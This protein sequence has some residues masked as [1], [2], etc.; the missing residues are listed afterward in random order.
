MNKII[1][2]EEITLLL[3]EDESIL[4][5]KIIN[6]L[7]IKEFELLKYEIVKKAI[8]SRNKK[9]I[10]FVYS[11]DIELKNNELF[12]ENKNLKPK[13]K[14]NIKRHKIRLIEPFIYEIP[15]ISKNPKNRPIIIWTWPSWLFA[16]LALALAWLKPII[17]E[18]WS[19]VEK[20]VSQVHKFFTTW[21]LD[22]NSNVQF[23]EWWA[24]TFSDWKLYTL[25][26]DKRS[27]FIFS[28]FVEAGAP[29]EILYNAKPHIWTDRLRGVVRNLRKKIISLGWEFYF[30]TLMTDIEVENWKIKAVFLIN[31]EKLNTDDLILAIWHS[32]R[33][34][35][36]M[37]YK[38]WLEIT[39]KPFAIWLRIE[40]KR[41]M[42]NKSQFWD[43]CSH[44]KLPT[45]SYK[46]VSHNENTRSVYSFCMCPGWH[47]VAASSE[48]WRLTVNW[49]S[50]YA[51]NSP[52][53]NSA[54]LVNVLPSDFGSDHPLAWI[55]FQRKW[56]QKAF[57][58][59]WNNYFA[60]AQL[61]WD[62]LKK[63]PSTKLWNISS[64]YKPN[65]KLTSLDEC[66]PDFVIDA[67]REAIPIFDKKI[68]WFA[69]PNALL[70]GIEARSSSVVRFARNEKCQS[71]I[72]W[73]YPA[74]EWAWYAWW[75]TSSA[76]D[77]LI[78]WETIINKYL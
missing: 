18:R 39:Q 1:R 78:V 57:E 29:K 61:V 38:R 64:T 70:V 77:W 56:E 40:H 4:K 51:Q 63:A 47:I 72:S 65:I 9:N 11:L 75:I 34:T 67:I 19:Q 52:N 37:L 76:I 59:W 12:F 68:S 36:E 58:S 46:L 41:E 14:D 2:I 42:I 21:I 45:A 55:E 31:W 44:I 50:E 49:M 48:E 26:N 32:A 35:Y 15:T 28:E 66:L 13:I 20:R 7:W 27:K 10:L 6:L 43:A 73:I 25:V 5:T 23:W 74:G 54:L 53:S 71:N 8:D 60:P 24:W 30:D 62:F 22:T 3:N 69:D 17:I 16:W 33:D